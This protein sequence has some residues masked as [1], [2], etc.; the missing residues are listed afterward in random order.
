MYVYIILMLLSL[1]KCIP[2]RFYGHVKLW[3]TYQI[4]LHLKWDELFIEFWSLQ[5]EE[6]KMLH[7]SFAMFFVPSLVLL[8]HFSFDMISYEQK[9]QQHH[10]HHRNHI[11]Y[12]AHCVSVAV[13]CVVFSVRFLIWI[14]MKT[15]SAFPVVLLL[16]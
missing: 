10:Y 14:I 5:Q 9:Q 7:A 1:F 13:V 2:F 3:R 16:W 6:A 4:L 15:F 11:T 12:F 8:R